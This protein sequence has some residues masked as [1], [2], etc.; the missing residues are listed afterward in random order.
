MVSYHLQDYHKTTGCDNDPMCYYKYSWS[1]LCM[2]DFM[3][4]LHFH[5]MPCFYMCIPCFYHV[6]ILWK[7][8]CQKW[9][10]KQATTMVIIF[11]ETNAL[12]IE[13]NRKPLP[14]GHTDSIQSN[15]IITRSFFLGL[16]ISTLN[17]SVILTPY[18]ISHNDNRRCKEA[19]LIGPWRCG[20]IS[21]YVNFEYIVMTGI[22][23]ISCK[24]T[25]SWMS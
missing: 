13:H 7:M 16:L 4:W 9:R 11:T 12:N 2:Y 21:K 20:F 24:I 10:N 1:I 18:A 3:L 15:L 5:F 8:L 19:Q 23:N 25:R 22:S 17:F 14:S 6:C